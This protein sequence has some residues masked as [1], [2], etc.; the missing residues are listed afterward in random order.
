MTVGASKIQMLTRNALASIGND[1][2]VT[3]TEREES[4]AQSLK[5]KG[6]P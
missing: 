6:S 2:N 3:Q 4:A 5:K 1:T